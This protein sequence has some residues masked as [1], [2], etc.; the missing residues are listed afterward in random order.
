MKGF[1]LISLVFCAIAFAAPK[2]TTSVDSSQ[3]VKSCLTVYYMAQKVYHSEKNYYTDNLE[4]LG[5]SSDLCKDIHIEASVSKSG[6]RFLVTASKGKSVSS[7]DN[8]TLME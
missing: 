8:D 1:V 2:K 6:Q 4:D 3:Q 7:I 5:I